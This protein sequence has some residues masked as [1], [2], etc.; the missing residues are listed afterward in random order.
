MSA[1]ILFSTSPD[2]LSTIIRLTTWSEWS[3]CELMRD[4]GLLLGADYP[5]GVDYFSFENRL[6][7]ATKWAIA[8]V[9]G[10]NEARVWAFAREQL[11]KPYDLR[12]A[13][14]IPFRS[15]WNDPA[16]WWCSELVA[17]SFLHAGVV[18]ADVD[19]SRI[20]QQD[21][22]QTPLKTII[23]RGTGGAFRG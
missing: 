4:D 6:R 23:K 5:Q 8:E 19:R 14:G 7:L 18:L 1:R 20:T 10:A 16:R 9:A 17:A 15:N 2:K 13:L 11:G 3:H 21:L 12:G 22:W